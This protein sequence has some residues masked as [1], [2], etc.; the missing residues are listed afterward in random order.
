MSEPD[1]HDAKGRLPHAMFR[2]ADAQA[3]QAKAEHRKVDEWAAW[4]KLFTDFFEWLK[5]K[6]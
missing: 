1:K 4:R 6:G 3:E 2:I 5:K